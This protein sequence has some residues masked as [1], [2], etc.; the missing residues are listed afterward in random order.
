MDYTDI[1]A[2]SGIIS[3]IAVISYGLYKLL[4]H[5]HCTSACC[6]R[7]LFDVSVNLESTAT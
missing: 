3:L 1:G 5:S 6:S 2:T 7:P 4:A